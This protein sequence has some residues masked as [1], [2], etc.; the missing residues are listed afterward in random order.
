[1]ENSVIVKISLVVISIIIIYLLCLSYKF[2]LYNSYLT[3]IWNADNEFCIKSDIS[4][5][6][7]YFNTDDKKV[8][9]IINK[10]TEIIENTEF[11]MDHE[12][13]LSLNNFNINNN[14]IEYNVELVAAKGDTMLN[15][16]NYT[17]VVSIPNSKMVLYHGD[18]I[19][20]ILYKD[21][22]NSN[23]LD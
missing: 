3:G 16:N 14:N 17:L 1:M 22:I 10:D 15:H 7:C 11:N 21:V 6:L 13:K 12:I 18:T 23:L 20:A 9:L 8:N 19:Y 2:Y 5:M 4:D